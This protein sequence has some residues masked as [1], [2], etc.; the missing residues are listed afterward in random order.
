MERD[1]TPDPD[2]QPQAGKPAVPSRAPQGA[3]LYLRWLGILCA[4]MAVFCLA[5]FLIG[6]KDPSL[7]RLAT[8]IALCI[9]SPVCLWLSKRLS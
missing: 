4:I 9:A 5:G 8:F 3:P 7:G 1:K 2:H 6:Y